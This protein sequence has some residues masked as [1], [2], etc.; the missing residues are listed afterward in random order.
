MNEDAVFCQFPEVMEPQSLAFTMRVRK[1][2]FFIF[3]AKLYKPIPNVFNIA[4]KMFPG[5]VVTRDGHADAG[6]CGSC[7]LCAYSRI[8]G[9]G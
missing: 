6:I 9:C 7:G 4:L 2:I 8:W 1:C 3:L 5:D